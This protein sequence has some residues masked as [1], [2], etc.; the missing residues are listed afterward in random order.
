MLFLGYNTCELRITTTAKYGI[1]VVR[2]SVTSENV[3]PFGTV[4]MSLRAKKR[5]LP[6]YQFI[7]FFQEFPKIDGKLIS[8]N[9]SVARR[10]ERTD[11]QRP[12][13]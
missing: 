13:K 1:V 12:L 8:C 7:A 3:G 4:T 5:G 6:V 9:S 10:Q 11:E 2:F